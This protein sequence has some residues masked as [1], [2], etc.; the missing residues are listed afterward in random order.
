MQTRKREVLAHMMKQ[1]PQYVVAES[2]EIRDWFA[3][4]GRHMVD[5][6]FIT[7]SKQPNPVSLGDRWESTYD[8]TVWFSAEVEIP[9]RF[10]GRRMY[11]EFD[12]GGEAIVRINGKIAGGVSNDKEWVYRDK[13]FLP[14]PLRKF[15][16]CS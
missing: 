12:F 5:G 9:E 15:T 6:K 16:Q 4:A 14:D 3:I 11:L 10:I 2:V 1:I 8:E 13:I 7:Y